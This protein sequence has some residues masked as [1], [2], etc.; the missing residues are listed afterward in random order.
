[1]DL[2]LFAGLKD[3]DLRR[4][5]LLVAE[6]RFLVERLLNSGLPVLGVLCAPRF[7][8]HLGAL[9]CGT[10]PLQVVPEERIAEIAG[11]RFHRG[12]LAVAGR[13]E[14]PPMERLL[15][16][17]DPPE[18]LVACPDLASAENLGGIVRTTAALG[19]GGVLLGPRCCDPFSRKALKVSMG[20]AFTVPLARMTG[21]AEACARLAEAGYTVVASSLG[22]GATPLARFRRGARLCLVFGNEAAGV[23]EPWRSC[24]EV[25]LTIPMR[26]GTDSLN[27]ASAAAIFLYALQAPAPA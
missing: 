3:R 18:T 24:C 20:S 7:A 10:S 1:M 11:F 8:E 27:V 17:P 21:E 15:E 23:G 2:S 4:E 9:A 25:L 26:E 14:L 13:P 5:G 22:P 12:A 19:A 16:S 6:G